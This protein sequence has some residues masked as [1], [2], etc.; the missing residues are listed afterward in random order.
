MPI[1]LALAIPAGVALAS[2]GIE[3]LQTRSLN[4][5]NREFAVQQADKARAQALD[6]FNAT[7]A[8]NAP[9]AQ[10][11]RLINAGLNPAM[12]YGGG[13]AQTP[14]TVVRGTAP[15]QNTQTAM[16]MGLSNILPMLSQIK[17]IQAQA[18]GVQ[19]DNAAKAR[20]LA[21]RADAQDQVGNPE[22]MKS[23]L[24]QAEL[25]KA[26]RDLEIQKETTAAE[27]K[28]KLNEALTGALKASEQSYRNEN[29]LPLEKQKAE[30]D[31]E[32]LK[33]AIQQGQSTATILEMNAQ[34]AKQG[35]YPTDPAYL[36]QAVIFLNKYVK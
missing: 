4:K 14:S 30:Q 28:I 27:I 23:Q 2:K 21:N 12:M 29:L 6:D 11:Q 35:I 25:N 3:A 24:V 1:P 16:D 34:L 19:L 15:A 10:K 8:F 32:M 26:I 17:L 31:L 5:K 9:S 22:I 33:I 13:P 36:R 7:N 18:E 20:D